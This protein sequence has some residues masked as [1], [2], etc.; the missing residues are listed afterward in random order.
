MFYDKSF[1]TDEMVR[2]NYARR[3][4]VSYTIAKMQQ[5]RAKGLAKVSEQEAGGI[6]ARTLILWG[7]HDALLD[8]AGAAELDRVIPNSRVVIL[9]KSGHIPQVE[10]P[11]RFNQL[12]REFLMAADA[13]TG[14]TP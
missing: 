9:E 11:Q 4:R 6:R 2:E 10:E 5:A 12:V 1:V 8:P 7:K 13:R 3:L 14:G